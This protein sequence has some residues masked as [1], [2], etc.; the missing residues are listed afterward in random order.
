MAQGLTNPQVAERLIMSRATV[1]THV[2]HCFTKPGIT[3]RTELA[4]LTQQ[5]QARSEP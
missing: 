1:K 4:T 2:S 3:N 5:H